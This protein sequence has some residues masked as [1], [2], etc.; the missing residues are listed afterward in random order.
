VL[1][2]PAGRQS[3]ALDHTCRNE[4]AS[5]VQRTGGEVDRPQGEG[6]VVSARE[7][8]DGRIVSSDGRRYPRQAPEASGLRNGAA[9]VHVEDEQAGRSSGW[10]ERAEDVEQTDT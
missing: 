5:V 4:S 3:G 10:P 7:A 1:D 2:L 8:V 9:V 6:A